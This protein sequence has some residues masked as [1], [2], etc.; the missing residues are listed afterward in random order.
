MGGGHVYSLKM[1]SQGTTNWRFSTKICFVVAS[2]WTEDTSFDL[3][4]QQ[5]YVDKNGEG[6]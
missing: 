4:F 5:N 1:W 2:V 3:S 6:G